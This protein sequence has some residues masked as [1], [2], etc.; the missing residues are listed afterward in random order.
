[1]IGAL[2][3]LLPMGSNTNEMR[4]CSCPAAS[5]HMCL[6]VP[7]DV[8]LATWCDALSQISQQLVAISV[9]IRYC[10]QLKIP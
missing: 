1:M 7:T 2:S 5:H 8:I 6:L 10:Y 9:F 4:L 3:I